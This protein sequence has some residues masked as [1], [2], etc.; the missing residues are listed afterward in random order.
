MPDGQGIIKHL[1]RAE[2][3]GIAETMQTSSSKFTSCL[4]TEETSPMETKSKEYKFYAPGIGLVE[5]G[6]MKLV[7]CGKAEK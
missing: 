5:E 2:I 1:D 4:E 6:S 7:R 3:K